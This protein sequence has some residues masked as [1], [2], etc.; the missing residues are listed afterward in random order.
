M[1]SE[2]LNSVQSIFRTDL[3]SRNCRSNQCGG[4]V[5]NIF[6]KERESKNNNTP[7]NPHQKQVSK[8]MVMISNKKSDFYK[9]CFSVLGNLG[10]L[11]LFLTNGD[12]KYKAADSRRISLWVQEFLKKMKFGLL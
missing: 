12:T 11:E 2:E 5:Q 6:L 8:A 4:W 9:S 10:S 7:K 1:W 3:C